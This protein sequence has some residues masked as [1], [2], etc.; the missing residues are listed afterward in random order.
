[1]AAATAVPFLG[2]ANGGKSVLR[3]GLKGLGKLFGRGGTN[4]AETGVDIGAGRFA[5]KSFSEKF[6]SGGLFSGRTI[7]DVAGDL[8]TGVLSPK[9]VPINVVVRDGTTLIS[10]TRSAQ[11]LTRAG[12]PRGQWNVIN[13]TGDDVYESLVSGQLSRNRLSSSG[14][15]FPG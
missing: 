5:Q 13:R 9:D 1:A 14:Y 10:N 6:S 3:Q 12:I 11:A 4:A 8:R 7:D 2:T 15:E